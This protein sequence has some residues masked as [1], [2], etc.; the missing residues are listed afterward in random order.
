[1][2]AVLEWERERADADRDAERRGHDAIAAGTDAV[3]LD[4]NAQLVIERQRA[5]RTLTA[6]KASQSSLAHAQHMHGHDRDVLAIV[7]HDLRGPLSIIAANAQ[8][9][10]ERAQEPSMRETADD[11]VR[12]AARMGRLLTDLLDAVRID[13]GTLRIVTASHDAYALAA[14]IVHSYQPLFASRKLTFISEIP[15]G[16][17]FAPFDYDRIVQVLSNLLGNALKFTP[18]NGMVRLR[19]QAHANAIEFMVRD[20]GPGIQAADLPHVFDKFWQI[21]SVA[22]RGLGLGLH[23][24][25]SIVEAHGGRIWVESDFGQGAAFL[26]SLPTITGSAAV[27][28]DP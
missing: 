11:V 9:I 27:S 12:A 2:D 19:A 13:S 21:G 7:M 24:C 15:V 6:L 3:R 26:V 23:I 16:S 20:T 28:G 8:H 4:T 1:M 18:E 10:A 5:D 25:K 14:E 22:R 17:A